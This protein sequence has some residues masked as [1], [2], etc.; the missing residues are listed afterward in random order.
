MG[1][2][3]GRGGRW[4]VRGFANQP[5]GLRVVHGGGVGGG[6]RREACGPEEEQGGRRTRVSGSVK[7][8]WVQ[9]S[10]AGSSRPYGGVIVDLPVSLT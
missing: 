9:R 7:K 10:G 2:V 5:L 6:T 8:A 4:R 3:R 1:L